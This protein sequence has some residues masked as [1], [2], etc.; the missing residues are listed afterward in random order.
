[1]YF[2]NFY[3]SVTVIP[4]YVKDIGG[5]EFSLGIQSTLFFLSAVIFRLYFGPLADKKG[6]KLPLLIGTFVFATTPLLILFVSNHWMLIPIRIYQGIGLA[7]F[8]SSGSSFVA[9]IVP[10]ERVG[11]YIGAY[12]L[13]ITLA[14][15]VGP[16]SAQFATNHYGYTAWFSISFFIGLLSFLF[17][18]LIKNPPLP[19]CEHFSSI[20]N[21][22][23]ALKN[24]ELWPIYLG[25]FLVSTA[26][27][28]ILN[29]ASIYISTVTSLS[30]PGIYFTFFALA[31][32]L[33]NLSA[34]YLS[35]RFGREIVVWPSVMLLALGSFTLYFL[36][37]NPN[38]LVLSSCLSGIGFSG[39][40]S[41]L[42]AWL[43][44]KA[45]Q[46]IRGTVLS[47]QESAIDLAVALGAFVI[48]TSSEFISLS[49]AFA[50]IGLIVF[51]VAIIFLFF[52]MFMQIK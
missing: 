26:Y 44:D 27:G 50:L 8:L 22:I 24:K 4:L 23:K 52:T 39:G 13:I 38:F 48:G 3:T 30:N 29:F 16:V 20:N 51:T 14:L 17:I 11:T 37:G 45:E 19:D 41:A 6:R 36:P 28:G 1:M 21:I 25:V 47:F 33:A 31:G 15:L 40:I 49:L 7:T 46:K 32:V 43:V 10:K 35:D 42:I 34:G 2:I 5:D 12:R 18:V 9:D